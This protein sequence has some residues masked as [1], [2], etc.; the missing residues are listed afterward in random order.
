MT[1]FRATDT[2]INKYADPIA[3]GSIESAIVEVKDGGDYYSV[4]D[5]GPTLV[6]VRLSRGTPGDRATLWCRISQ[7]LNFIPTPGTSVIV[8]IPAGFG[9]S[10]GAAMIIGASGP[11]PSNQFDNSK[12]KLD[13]GPDYDLVIK[14]R[15]ITLTDYENRYL[16]LGPTYGVKIGDATASGAILK[17]ARWAF[18][19]AED[20]DAKAVLELATDKVQIL[21]KD[22][23]QNSILLQDGTLTLAG[24]T[25][26]C[27]TAGGY[28]G[29]LPSAASPMTY[30]ASTA[31]LGSAAWFISPT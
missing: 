10:P 11:A 25:F 9:Y 30:G 15:S 22:D 19:V 7:P 4:E 14:A 31:S 13:F 2:E 1:G 6:H 5:G 26:R 27:A 3:S 24:T 28:L 23:K 17:D 20:G 18:Y 8:A 21:Q 12:A 16:T 29:V